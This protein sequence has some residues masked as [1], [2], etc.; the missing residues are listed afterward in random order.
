MVT[1][2]N[3]VD[4][5]DLADLFVRFAQVF[6]PRM[7]VWITSEG[8]PLCQYL[9]T[10]FYESDD[11]DGSPFTDWVQTPETSKDYLSLISDHVDDSW[12]TSA[13]IERFATRWE[14]V[15]GIPQSSPPVVPLNM[16]SKQA[17]TYMFLINEWTNPLLDVLERY[18]TFQ[19]SQAQLL[20]SYHRYM[21][22]RTSACIQWDLIIPLLGFTSE[23]QQEEA[24]GTQFYLT[25]FTLEEKADVWNTHFSES[26]PLQSSVSVDIQTFCSA[27][28]KLTATRTQ[29]RGAY[30]RMNIFN[31]GALA[32]EREKI[33]TVLEDIITA[34]R[35][36]KAGNVGT[37]VIFE[38][39]RAAFFTQPR[40]RGI[41]T[42]DIVQVPGGNLPIYRLGAADL[43]VAGK[44]FAALQSLNTQ[45]QLQHGK[46]ASQNG[47]PHLH[48]DL[49]LPLRRFN[50]SYS[51]STPED[52]I[53]DLTIA[54]ESGLFD[55]QERQITYKFA[56]RGAAL[57]AMDKAKG[58]EPRKS[59]TLLEALYDVRSGIVHSG[60]QLADLDDRL[61][62]LPDVGIPCHEFLQECENIVREILKA[63]VRRRAKRQ[64]KTT[65]V[66]DMKNWAMDGIG[67]NPV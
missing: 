13:E 63:L 45:E 65:I 7:E 59:K 38:R 67:G 51:R 18:N 40:M 23:L 53:V 5:E 60:K 26:F 57:L 41:Y 12:L 29:Q 55:R 10:D 8:V 11:E 46:Q 54:L 17:R 48:G 50:Q 34:L 49:T 16:V 28:F 33:L 27:S 15:I 56:M 62:K 64:S 2:Q 37:L 25:P 1:Q 20:D 6:L 9:N 61:K 43:S 30:E 52:R 21:V 22:E 39:T 14:E 58:W 4:A 47:M 19:P 42:S 44:L 24:I 35:L 3:H 31:R 32:A 66:H 36:V